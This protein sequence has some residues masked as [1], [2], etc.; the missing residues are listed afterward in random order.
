MNKLLM[1]MTSHRLD[2]LKICLHC[3]EKAG[4]W[5]YFDK[6]V[7]LL[8]GVVG[9]HLNYV[10][11]YMADRPNVDWDTVIGPR[12]RSER[13]SALENQCVERYPEYLY[14]KTDED[15]F[16]AKG[17]AEC[18]YETWEAHKDNDQLACITPMM[19]NTSI[20]L[21]Q[22]LTTLYPEHLAEFKKVFGQDPDPDGQS[23]T[24]FNPKIGEWA[25]RIFI[26]LDKANEE[27]VKRLKESGVD[28]WYTFSH[29]FTVCAVVFDYRHWKNM[30]GIP[31]KDE[32][33]WCQWIDDHGHDNVIDRKPIALHY[34]YGVQQDWIDRSHLLEDIALKNMP[35]APCPGHL[36]YWTPWIKRIAM[37]APKALQRK[38][39]HLFKAA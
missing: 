30:G 36:T 17:F 16:I 26:D 1:V 34:S 15:V 10:N 24:R 4:S 25:N 33:E 2:C 20:G 5:E 35:N 21:H 3:H 39:K 7:F 38:L 14:M 29:S 31:P 23:E 8:N 13:I 11:Q 37:Q 32:P 9:E 12:G 28:R 18:M 19:A 27:N 6:V 22:A